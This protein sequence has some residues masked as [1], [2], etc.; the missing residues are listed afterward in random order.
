MSRMTQCEKVLRYMQEFGSITQK[1]AFNVIHCAR[2][3]GRI[4]DLK[5]QGYEID[6]VME[7]RR[8]EAGVPYSFARYSLKEGAGQ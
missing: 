5:A 4:F 7:Y 3:S 2:L 1:D 6:S 8:D